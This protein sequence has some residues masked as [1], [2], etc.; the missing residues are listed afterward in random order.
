MGELAQIVA[1]DGHRLGAYKAVVPGN[2]RWVVVVQE[3]FGVNPHIRKVC[4]RF[5]QAGFNAIAP[6]LFDRVERDVEMDYSPASIQ[7]YM[8]F[9]EQMKKPDVLADLLAAADSTGVRKVGIVGYCFGGTVAWWAA[10]G[11]DQFA[12]AS[13]WYG[14]GI[15]AEK[16][17]TPRCPVQMHFGAADPHIPPAHVQSIRA[18][19]PGVEIHV[20]DGADHGF[21]CDERP[22]FHAP[23]F[24]LAFDRT[25]AFLG[26]HV[27]AA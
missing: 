26:T 21:G 2:A 22:S 17:L 19:Q 4:D 11:L 6:A 25:T 20:Y 24:Q 13:C 3:A 10:A 18:A 14:G 12:A 1:G 9:R 15:F 16:D 8:K 23:S 27:R 7:R 5:A